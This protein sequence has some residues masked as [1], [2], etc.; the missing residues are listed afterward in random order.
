M[1]YFAVLNGR[2]AQYP[3]SLPCKPRKVSYSFAVTRSFCARMGY[4]QLQRIEFLIRI[5]ARIDGIANQTRFDFNDSS[6]RDAHNFSR[7]TQ[8]NS[9]N[10]SRKSVNSILPPPACPIAKAS[11]NFCSFTTALIFD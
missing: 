7:H 5:P 8:I 10:L 9:F 4:R 11:A 3:V 1:L 6:R 2:K